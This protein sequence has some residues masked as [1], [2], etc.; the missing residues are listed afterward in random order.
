[1]INNSILVTGASGFIG[2]NL[3]R[4]L[5]NSGYDV[6]I[7]IR[8]G[9]D[10][11]SIGLPE[12][13]LRLHVYDGSLKSLK[14]IFRIVLPT[15][16]FH[17]AS[18]FL[19]EHD[20]NNLDNLLASNIGFSTQLIEAM[21]SVGVRYLINTGTSWQHYK[22]ADYSPVNL[23]AATKQAFESIL[24]FY[25][26]AKGL[27]VVTLSLFDTFGPNDTRKKLLQLLWKTSAQETP[28]LMSPGEQKINLVYIDDVVKAFEIAFHQISRMPA[29]HHKFGVRSLNDLTLRKVV[30]IFEATLSVELNIVWGGREYRT[31]EVM[32]PWANSVAL[33]GWRPKVTLEEGLLLTFCDKTGS[34]GI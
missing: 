15:H 22:D 28:L 25:I 30:E 14:R 13:S 11:N 6:H 21:V 10:V 5:N 2:S 7:V 3:V 24:D 1:M 18:L 16:V 32:T 29:G 17:L 8:E 33:P 27:K 19:A 31:R 26:Q 23:Y 4:Y 34:L 9:S 20:E 12:G